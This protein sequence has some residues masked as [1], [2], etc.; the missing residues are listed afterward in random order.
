MHTY[1]LKLQWIK[2]SKFIERQKKIKIFSCHSNK[3]SETINKNIV[4]PAKS[5]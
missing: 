1:F 4:K 5:H 2:I 3:Y